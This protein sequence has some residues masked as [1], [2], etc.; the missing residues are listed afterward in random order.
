LIEVLKRLR[1]DLDPESGETILT[2]E[3]AARIRAC[4]FAA[5]AGL[6]R[7]PLLPDNLIWWIPVL[8]LLSDLYGPET[9]NRW[10]PKRAAIRTIKPLDPITD[11][12]QS[13]LDLLGRAAGH[14]LTR[15]QLQQ[16]VSRRFPTRYLDRMLHHL[17]ALDRIVHEGDWLYPCSRSDFDAM[18]RHARDPRR[19]LACVVWADGSRHCPPQTR[20][21]YSVMEHRLKLTMSP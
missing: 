3:E 9:R 16:R 6:W 12:E 17:G 11:H 10:H 1:H 15:R 19:K 7:C 8:R 14:H 2:T 4:G 5:R 21:E 20:V 18:Q 13:I